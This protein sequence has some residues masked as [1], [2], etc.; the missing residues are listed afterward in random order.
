MPMEALKAGDPDRIGAY[1]LV[2]RLG[3]GGM[4]Q[5]FLGRSAGGRP[6]AVKVI[7]PEYGADAAFRRSFAR[8]VEAARRVGGFFTAQVVDADPDAERPWL[9]SAFV[10]GPSLYT[11]VGEHGALP[12]G[13]LRVLAAGLAE[14]LDAIHRCGLVHRD[15]KPGNVVVAADGPRVIDF[16]IARA[17]EASSH[18]VSGVVA[19]TPAY[20]SPE[21]ARGDRGIGPASDVFALG[22]VLAFAATGRAPFG[23]GH[24][25]AMLYRIVQ[26]EP[27]LAPVDHELR[28]LVAACLAKDPDAR[29]TAAG[30]LDSLSGDT[31]TAPWVP[32][33][34]AR[35]ISAF[36]AAH[37]VGTGRGDDGATGG[38]APDADAGG[39]SGAAAGGI[40]DADAEVDGTTL[41]HTPADAGTKTYE[42]GAAPGAPPPS[43]RRRRGL[44]RLIPTRRGDGRDTPDHAGPAA[45]ERALA[46]G[47]NGLPWGAGVADFRARFPGAAQQNGEWWVT[48]RGPETFCGVT[49]DAQY[50][51]NAR[52]RLC[53]IAFYPEPG[54]REH[55][56][57]SVLETLGAPDGT[58][59][60]W[61]RGKVVV[62][63]KV[64]GVVATLTHTGFADR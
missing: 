34:V 16:G 28:G 47:W 25:A 56:P 51:F 59:T 44:A 24:P 21:Q 2:G 38:G 42:A 49:M 43:P 6:V 10:P 23:D 62:D 46:Q 27:D 5:V 61:T 19:G 36:E 26:E 45:P 37:G 31:V 8:E 52:G 55:L 4:G 20:M 63:V 40:A 35:M 11:V 3:A 32:P 64:A 7:R 48:G 17:L 58:S 30:L 57:V 54:D 13:A 41:T 33:A 22:S 53:L 18:T 12:A 29:P 39:A 15:L 9:V 1:R 14:G 60:R 50:A